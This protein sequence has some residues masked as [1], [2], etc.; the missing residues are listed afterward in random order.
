M[1]IKE[2]SEMEIDEDPNI[3]SKPIFELLHKAMY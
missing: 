3:K 1:N 2:N